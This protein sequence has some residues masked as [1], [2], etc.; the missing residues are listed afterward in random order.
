MFE[1]SCASLTVAILDCNQ[2]SPQSIPMSR[3]FTLCL[4]QKC[5]IV[6]TCD[7]ELK[8]RIRKQPGVPILYIKQRQFTVER[9]PDAYGGA[10]AVCSICP[11]VFTRTSRCERRNPSS[12]S[13]HSIFLCSHAHF[14]CSCLSCSTQYIIVSRG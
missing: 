10:A 9:M 5:Y 11:L 14:H 6:A 2:R 1:I 3:L 4:Q 13:L 7:R 8:R 12:H